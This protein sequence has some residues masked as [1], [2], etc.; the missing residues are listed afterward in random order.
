MKDIHARNAPGNVT[1]FIGA[2]ALAADDL[3]ARGLVVFPVGGDDGKAPLVRGWQKQRCPYPA[4]RIGGWTDRFPAAGIGIATGP[5][6]GLTV[7]DIDDAELVEMMILRFGDTPVK[8][9]TPSGGV[10]L[11]FRH[12]GEPS[13]D[14]R[15]ESLAVDV[16]AAGGFVVAPP[17]VRPSGPAVG[18]AYR[19]IAGGWDDLD[20]LPTIAPGALTGGADT[21]SLRSVE[22]G[23][24]DNTLIRHALSVVRTCQTFEALV[25]ALTDIRDRT[26][27]ASADDPFTDA[28]VR[29]VARSAW[30]IHH[31]GRNWIGTKGTVQMAQ[32]DFE[33]LVRNPDALAMALHLRF[34]HSARCARGDTFTLSPKAMADTEVLPGWKDPRRYRAARDFLVDVGFVNRVHRGGRGARDPDRFVLADVVKGAESVPNVTEHPPFLPNAKPT[35][36]PSTPPAVAQAGDD[37]VVIDVGDLF[38]ATG[39]AVAI[40]DVAAWPGGFMP[41]EL[42]QAVRRIARSR[43]LTHDA[44]ARHVGCRRSTLGNV[45]TGRFGAG[46]DLSAS[47]RNFLMAEMTE[48]MIDVA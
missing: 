39:E 31:E 18:R 33:T 16:K 3:T 19:F 40:A 35:A 21:P 13:G 45:L 48:R 46:P 8:V 14:L 24:R 4:Q 41:S 43:G 38:A 10:H 9:E 11:Y 12:Q 25:A 26:F 32:A 27:E 23:R 2:F 22:R 20:R 34:V 44:L 5:G 6:S 42:A 36:P 29:K 15:G 17:S 1:D 47:L 30:K 37:H 7:I 28:D